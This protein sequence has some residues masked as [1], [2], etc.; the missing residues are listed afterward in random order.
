M[1]NL[2]MPHGYC[3]NH[4][5]VDRF[6]SESTALR[7]LGWPE[8]A[9]FNDEHR[10][11]IEAESE[12]G[13]PHGYD[14]VKIPVSCVGRCASCKEPWVNIPRHEHEYVHSPEG[15]SVACCA[16]RDWEPC[17][18]CQI[19]KADL[20]RVRWKSKLRLLCEGYFAHEA[21]VVHLSSQ[22]PKL[23]VRPEHEDE[24]AEFVRCPPIE[25]FI[26][27]RLP[28][29]R[30]NF[31]NQLAR[32]REAGKRGWFGVRRK[33]WF[34]KEARRKA[35]RWVHKHKAELVQKAAYERG[36]LQAV[37]EDW[38]IF[39]PGHPGQKGGFIHEAQNL[40]EDCQDRKSARG[41][42]EHFEGRGQ[43]V[44][45]MLLSWFI[46]KFKARLRA[47]G[48]PFRDVLV[49]EIGDS[50]AADDEGGY[51]FHALVCFLPDTK[52]SAMDAAF[53]REWHAVTGNSRWIDW[54]DRVEGA[55]GIAKYVAKLS[56]YLMKQ[57]M[58][59]SRVRSAQNLRLDDAHRDT[60]LVAAGLLKW[61]AGFE[62][63][64]DRWQPLVVKFKNQGDVQVG[65]Q[66][67]SPFTEEQ[68]A[69]VAAHEF[70]LCDF[71]DIDWFAGSHTLSFPT[72]I[73]GYAQLPVHVKS[74]T[75]QGS[76]FAIAV[77]ADGE[78]IC[79]IPPGCFVVSIHSLLHRQSQ[80]DRNA[81]WY[82]VST[83]RD[84]FD[85]DGEP[86]HSNLYGLFSEVA[87]HRDKKV[88]A[89]ATKIEEL[90]G[91][92]LYELNS[93]FVAQFAGVPP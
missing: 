80:F 76:P 89:A 90:R 85:E 92:V 45:P 84:N 81:A 78:P 86:I 4:R 19:A 9:V 12:F 37:V 24:Y 68:L 69:A 6:T 14:W 65:Y 63:A 33:S 66:Y 53:R 25:E 40:L 20:K 28:E 60:A 49:L 75:L 51:H 82:E 1:G 62:S 39:I 31:K 36:W 50:Q 35:T 42:Y 17:P 23:G 52:L 93:R 22:V 70:V 46:T 72:D 87:D 48:I 88:A 21:P 77:D 10:R 55:A 8:Q 56:G 27:N 58:S 29:E 79:E 71:Q 13:R 7:R 44:L 5:V 34:S 57:H 54:F 74:P 83:H 32:R 16:E 91:A 41:K 15:R 64:A 59:F 3:E 26:A 61:P 2:L 38:G 47:A 18:I 11:R 67:V 43:R 73:A 30:R